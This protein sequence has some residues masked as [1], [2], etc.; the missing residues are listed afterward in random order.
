MRWLARFHTAPNLLAHTIHFT[1][2]GDAALSHFEHA[3]VN[4]INGIKTVKGLGCKFTE[5]F[6]AIEIFVKSQSSHQ[7]PVHKQFKRQNAGSW[8]IKRSLVARRSK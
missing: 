5:K 6:R 4:V 7:C 3:W 8:S 2:Y 1:F